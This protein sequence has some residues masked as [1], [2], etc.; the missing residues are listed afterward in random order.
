MVIKRIKFTVSCCNVK[1][2]IYLENQQ[3]KINGTKLPDNCSYH[4]KA[5]TLD[6]VNTADKDFTK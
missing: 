2:E 5:S 3:I 6:R 4:P 1:I